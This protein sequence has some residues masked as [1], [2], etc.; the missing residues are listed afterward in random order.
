MTRGC[1]GHVLPAF[2]RIL[3]GSTTMRDLLM[4]WSSTLNAHLGPDGQQVV[5]LGY[6][7]VPH[8]NAAG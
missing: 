5:D 6:V 8:P 4:R 3:A 2:V 7:F 1:R